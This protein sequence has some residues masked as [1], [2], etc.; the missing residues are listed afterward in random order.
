MEA[1]LGEPTRQTPL[2]ATRQSVGRA[3]MSAINDSISV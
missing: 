2:I 1:A 3:Q